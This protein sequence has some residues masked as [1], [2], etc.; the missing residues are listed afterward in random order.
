VELKPS[1]AFDRDFETLNLGDLS[2]ES[3]LRRTEFW[4]KLFSLPA[5]E[6][7]TPEALAER[8][9]RLFAARL[10]RV[11]VLGCL[12]GESGRQPRLE[13]LQGNRT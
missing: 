1:D 2:A 6:G 11:Y 8:E 3:W 9:E 12:H 13:V 7:A 5:K 4:I 10:L